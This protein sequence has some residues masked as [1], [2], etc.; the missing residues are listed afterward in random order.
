MTIQ[1]RLRTC[2]HKLKNR[3]QPIKK[4]SAIMFEAASTIDNMLV[5]IQE[6]DEKINEADRKIQDI[7]DRLGVEL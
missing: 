1:A 5:V 3:A 6:R 4:P 2:G 7:V